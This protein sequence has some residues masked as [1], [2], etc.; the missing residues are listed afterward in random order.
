MYMLYER[1]VTPVKAFSKTNKRGEYAESIPLV[2][3][4]LKNFRIFFSRSFFPVKPRY[5]RNE[6]D[7]L[8]V[9]TEKFGIFYDIV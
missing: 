7:F 1:C 9:K 6:T 2:R 5:I 3:I 4:E 8:L